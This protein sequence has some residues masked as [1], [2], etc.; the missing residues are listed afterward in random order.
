MVFVVVFIILTGVVFCMKATG[1]TRKQLLLGWFVK[2]FFGVCFILIHSEIYGIGAITVDW[3]EYIH[4]SIVLNNVAYQSF[5]TYLKFLFGFSTDADTYQYLMNTNHWSAGDMGIINDSRNVLRVNSLLVFVSG[6]QVYVHVLFFAFFSFLGLVELFRA[7][8]EKLSYSQRFFWIALILFPSLGFWSSSVL[9][10]PLMLTGLALLIHALLGNLKGYALFWRVALGTI[11]MLLFK[12]YVLVCFLVCLP[13][14]FLGKKVFKK[15]FFLA[16]IV[17]FGAFLLF[18]AVN[19][20]LRKDLTHRLTRMQFDFMNVGRGGMHVAADSVFFYF[21]QDQY[22]SLEF[23]DDNTVR[24]KD[25]LIAKK[26]TPGLKYPFDDVRL[27]ATD[28]P[29]EIIFVGTQCGSYIEPTPIN[30]S[31]VQLLN[32]I[33]EA[34]VNAA[35]RPTFWDQGGLLK[36]ANFLETIALFSFLIFSLIRTSGFTNWDIRNEQIFLAC[37]AILL[38]VLIGW[39]TPVLGAL[40]RYRVPAYLAI[41]LISMI[42]TPNRIKKHE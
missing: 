26:V 30:N 32:N 40:V 14:Y 34:F 33:P 13:V 2:V 39:T 12:P 1:L 10:E 19:S 23:N 29:W 22:G 6:G 3:E 28:G 37:F 17:V 27:N 36:I 15:R 35:F 18:F 4:D 21:H 25:E 7:F 11:L 8:K 9:K 42:G 20:T 16:P 24:V 31:F 41:L 5:E 38:L